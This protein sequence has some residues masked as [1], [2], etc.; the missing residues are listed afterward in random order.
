M[1]NHHYY[2]NNNHQ[3]LWQHPQAVHHHQQLYDPSFEEGHFASLSTSFP[4]SHNYYYS[5]LP[6]CSTPIPPMASPERMDAA[7]VI[8]HPPPILPPPHP[9]QHLTQSKNNAFTLPLMDEERQ[10]ESSFLSNFQ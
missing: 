9:H 8:P 6:G 2:Y 7:V 1:E 5:S 3:Q 4:S 10:K